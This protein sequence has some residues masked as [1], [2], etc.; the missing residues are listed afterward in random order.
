MSGSADPYV[1]T[2]DNLDAI[3]IKEGT[4]PKGQSI[5]EDLVGNKWLIMEAYNHLGD[6]YVQAIRFPTHLPTYKL[7]ERDF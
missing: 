4:L 5:M 2:E 7:F 1:Q 3:E 6:N